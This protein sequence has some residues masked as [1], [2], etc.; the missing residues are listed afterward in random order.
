VIEQR[1]LAETV[2]LAL[3]HGRYTIT[4]VRTA[5]DATATL[6]D[7]QPH[8]VVLDTDAAGISAFSRD[9]RGRRS[10]SADTFLRG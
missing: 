6:A 4:L 5:A 2:K 3:G 7:W 10:S 1:V 8:L 9:R